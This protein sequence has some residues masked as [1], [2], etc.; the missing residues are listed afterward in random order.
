MIYLYSGKGS[1][2][3]LLIL[4]SYMSMDYQEPPDS[5]KRAMAWL[6]KTNTKRKLNFKERKIIQETENS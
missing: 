6:R 2:A 4:D 1:H 3:S 5:G